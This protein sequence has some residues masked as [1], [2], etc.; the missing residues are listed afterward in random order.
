MNKTTFFHKILVLVLAFSAFT[1]LAAGAQ[2]SSIS[3]LIKISDNPT[4]YIVAG[5][6]TKRPLFSINEFNSYGLHFSGVITVSQTQLDQYPA[7]QVIKTANN[8]TVYKLNSDFTKQPI[9]N[10]QAFLD[11]GF[12]PQD[13]VVV[14]TT[15]LGLYPTGTIIINGQSNNTNF[16]Q[17]VNSHNQNNIMADMANTVGLASLGQP[18]QNMSNDQVA[19]AVVNL[20]RNWNQFTFLSARQIQPLVQATAS[21]TLQSSFNNLRNYTLGYSSSDSRNDRLVLLYH[22]N[23]QG[24]VDQ[25]IYVSSLCSAATPLYQCK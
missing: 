6:N 22:T 13:I 11:L 16:E 20:T 12:R 14:N 7:V 5:N 10:Y 15:E 23:T 17:A 19:S 21:S 25:V 2:T 24:M 18:F 1:P 3:R 9:G 4:V 8:P